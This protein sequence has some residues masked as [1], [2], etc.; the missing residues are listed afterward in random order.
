[1][2]RWITRRIHDPNFIVTSSGS[3]ITFIG[4][5]V[6]RG[7]IVT[8]LSAAATLADAAALTVE[9][10][11]TVCDGA[12]LSSGVVGRSVCVGGIGGGGGVNLYVCVSWGVDEG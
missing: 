11:S 7:S 3:V 1:L 4:C 8:G 2:S 5:G 6:D 9:E 10:A 12:D